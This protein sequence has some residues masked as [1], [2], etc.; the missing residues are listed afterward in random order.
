MAGPAADGGP[1]RGLQRAGRSGQRGVTF[2]EMVATAT[3]LM[4]LASAIMPVARIAKRRQQEIEL[5][6]QLRII[7]TAI[8]SYKLA[9]DTGFIG[10]TDVELGSE[11]YPP[12]LET[13]V[14]GVNQVGR[15][16]HK[17]KFLRRI[18]MDPMTRSTEWGLRCY[19]DDPDST[20]WCRKNVWDVYT[21]YEGK[22]LDGTEYKDW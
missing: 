13:L 7:R 11:G 6:R 21:K 16:D 14:E 20:S 3:I 15:I 19:Q 1:A 17:L 8:D 18:P 2:V 10:G 9:V 22:A 12:D 5:R 4:I